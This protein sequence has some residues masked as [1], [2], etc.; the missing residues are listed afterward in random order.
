MIQ[1]QTCRAREKIKAKNGRL[2]TKGEQNLHVG[3][4]GKTSRSKR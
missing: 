2:K 3:D 1:S 4:A